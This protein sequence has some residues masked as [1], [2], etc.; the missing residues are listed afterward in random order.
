VP[1]QPAQAAY[2]AAPDLPCP[3]S[4]LEIIESGLEGLVDNVGG[5]GSPM[6]CVNRR[7]VPTPIGAV[8]PLMSLRRAGSKLGAYSQVCFYDQAV[9]SGRAHLRSKRYDDVFG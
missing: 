9:V 3:R 6:A 2:A 5:E 7:G 1:A 8:N 4:G